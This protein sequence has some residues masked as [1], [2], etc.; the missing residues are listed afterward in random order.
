MLTSSDNF[1]LA[2][3]RVRYF[4]RPDSRD[5]IGLK[6]FA[7]NR[8]YNLEMLRQSLV[9]RTFEPSYPEIKYQPKPSLTLRPMAV[10]A[11][12][13]RVIFQAI[14]N[15]I[16]EKGRST[17][18]M[19]TNRQSFANVLSKRGQKQFFAPWKR[20]YR[21]FQEKFC[22]LVEEGNVWLAETDLA[23]FYETIDHATL[24]KR[25]LEDKFLDER[26]LQHLEYYLSIWSSVRPGT[27][28]A[29][30][31]PQGCLASDLL[32]N[33]F[34][35]DL[36]R[37]L[38]IQEYHYLRY[39]D[40][41][42]VL[43]KTK[44]AVQ[45]GLI[46]ID[47]TLK[48]IGLLLQ[49][50]KTI[51]RRITDLGE[52]TDRLA[53]QLSEIDRRFNEPELP[54]LPPPDPLLEPSLHDVALL[55]EDFNVRADP[56]KPA[57]TVQQELLELFWKSKHSIDSDDGDPFAERHLRFC[58]YRLEPDPEIVAAILPFFVERP[59]LSE[60]IALYLRKC[61]L[62]KETVGHLRNV[63]ETHK[64][65]DSVVALAVDILVRQ[66]VSLRPQHDLFRQWLTNGNRD[67]RLL[68]VAAIALGE[69][70]DNMLVLLEAMRSSSPSVRRVATIQTLR[71]ARDQDEAAH[72]FN[73]CID[74]L[75]PVVIDAL[76]YQLYN[77][78]G[79]T[80]NDLEL[81]D[82]S[83]TD[84]C[85]ACAKGY[86]DTL[87]AIQPDYLRSVLAK[88]YN[89][90]FLDTMDFHALLGSDY[91]RASE[92]LWQAENSYLVNP[93][94]YVSQLDLFHEEVLYPI[95]VDKLHWKGTR[96]EL[97][98]VAF[99]DR[100]RYFL[101]NKVELASF[102][103][104]VL[105]CHRLRSSCSEAHTRLHRQLITTSPITWRQRDGLKKR[106]GAGYQEL[107]DWLAAG[108]P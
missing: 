37:E 90:K 64:V 94:R 60:I 79:L 27:Q 74:D 16:A 15:V 100:A 2:W 84:Y 43:A 99:P 88:N 86:D 14:A 34:L 59:W 95:L 3:E 85:V 33:I 89:V 72:I 54:E 39:V 17:L 82:Q 51:V 23:A 98:Q 71:L 103:S 92:F 53:A 24:F 63:I 93:S 96:G 19:V 105:E 76:L 61:E 67:W 9:E 108:C 78:W 6:V 7:A 81:D 65:Y 13:D 97:A 56:S 20:Q 1:S 35:Y 91:E 46:R 73:V 48:S 25:L 106:L 70:S 41:I 66:G 107:V 12:G 29:R 87:P 68:H 44:D 58:L 62:D 47:T 50:K 21:L 31:V 80:L 45:R 52:E 32:A 49:T 26:S 5:W 8:D 75:A 4:D 11:I 57:P 22:E 77:E 28:V 102:G 38:A 18:A 10:L 83:L 69:S 42:R 104:A 55:G 101:A 40:D 36:D 30:G